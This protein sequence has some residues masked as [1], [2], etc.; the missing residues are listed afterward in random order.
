M[1]HMSL[2]DT[3]RATACSTTVLGDTAAALAATATICIY[4]L[5]VLPLHIH[6]WGHFSC[7]ITKQTAAED[8]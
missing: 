2:L 4:Q 8:S 1:M 6:V 5:P 7:S 3:Y